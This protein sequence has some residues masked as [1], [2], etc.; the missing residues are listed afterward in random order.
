MSVLKLIPR[1]HKAEIT[2]GR[3]PS[4]KDRPVL[5][6]IMEN[7]DS[8]YTT[9]DL[10]LTVDEL[11]ELAK[12]LSDESYRIEESVAQEIIKKKEKEVKKKRQ[13][14]AKKGKKK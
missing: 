2:C 3:N 5:L 11:R 12:F 9:I 8:E 6:C 4:N 7:R 10:E 1:S 13:K 14:A